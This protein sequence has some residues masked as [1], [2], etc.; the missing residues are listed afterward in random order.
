MSESFSGRVSP[1]VVRPRL[2]EQGFHRPGYL[3]RLLGRAGGVALVGHRAVP[4]AGAGQGRR[5]AD[6]LLRVLGLRLQP[7]LVED[8]RGEGADV[9]VEAPGGLEEEAAVGRDGLGAREDVLEGRDARAVGVGALGDLRELV[10]VAEEDERLRGAADRHDVGEGHLARLV[11]EE[12]VDAALHRV[13]REEPLGAR[14]DL[15]AA[16]GEAR[17]DLLVR[18]RELDLGPRRAVA[19]VALLDDGHADPRLG[20]R[21]AD[22]VDEVGDGLVGGGADADPLPLLHELD[23]HPGAH[24][25]LARAGR[26]LDGEAAVVEGEGQAA[27]GVQGL[28]AGLRQR[29]AVGRAAEPRRAGRGAG[30]GRRGRG[31]RRRSRSPITASATRRSASRRTSC[32][33]ARRG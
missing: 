29:G 26:A 17:L 33:A 32:P 7:A 12:D 22:L 4:Q 27:P 1:F 31:P 28:L 10:R 14:G 23:D 24:V 3:P 18:R 25:G 15:E 2:P 9:G 20:G 13:A 6:P 21:R 16:L 11:H 30:R 5:A 8:L 19:V